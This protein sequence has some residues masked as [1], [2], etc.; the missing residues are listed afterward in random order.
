M[1]L[2]GQMPLFYPI[3]LGSKSLSKIANVGSLGALEGKIEFFSLV[4]FFRNARKHFNTFLI[5]KLA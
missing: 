5:L 4:S 2:Q 3:L 1:A